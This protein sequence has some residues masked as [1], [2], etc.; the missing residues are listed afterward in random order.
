M[1]VMALLLMSAE[2]SKGHY[3]IGATNG[4]YISGFRCVLYPAVT[5]TAS[6][7]WDS[8]PLSHSHILEKK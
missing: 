3:K 7:I 4:Q 2:I 8:K 1:G 5:R 6:T